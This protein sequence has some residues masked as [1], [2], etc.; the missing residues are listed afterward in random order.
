MS[1]REL[2]FLALGACC[3]VLLFVQMVRKVRPE[4]TIEKL[5]AMGLVGG[6]LILMLILVWLSGSLV[7]ALGV[8][9]A[10]LLPTLIPLGLIWFGDEL[11]GLTGFHYGLVNRESPGFLV[12]LFGWLFLLVIVGWSATAAVMDVLNSP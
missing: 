7:E 4:V 1:I 12:R 5:V 11:G 10:V 2:I 9:C 6:W 3:G 8:C